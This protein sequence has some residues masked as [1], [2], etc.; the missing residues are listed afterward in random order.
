[1]ARRGHHGNSAADS[2]QLRDMSRNAP[3]RDTAIGQVNYWLC[4]EPNI[5]TVFLGAREWKSPRTTI[6][7]LVVAVT[8]SHEVPSLASPLAA[9]AD[10][11]PDPPRQILALARP[12]P[13]LDNSCRESPSNHGYIPILSTLCDQ[14]HGSTYRQD[15]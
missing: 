5:T 8:V 12:Q 1:M 2:G 13:H 10:R 14:W 9:E 7:F 4:E 3:N 15:H 11:S 6:P